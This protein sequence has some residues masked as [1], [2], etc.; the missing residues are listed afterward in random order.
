M[1]Q[2]KL[3][4]IA[5]VRGGGGRWVH[6][7]NYIQTSQLTLERRLLRHITLC[8]INHWLSFEAKRLLQTIQNCL[9]F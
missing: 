1:Y 6:S 3:M 8:F 9:R 5:L 7:V 2:Y 4:C